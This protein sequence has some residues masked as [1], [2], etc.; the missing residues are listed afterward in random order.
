MVGKRKPALGNGLE[1]MFGIEESVVEE[2]K[3]NVSRETF[4]RL[5]EIEPNRTQPRRN[6][7]E[8]ALQE[9]ADS[10]KQYGVIQ[11]IVVQK[12]GKRYE[13]IAG[14]RRWRAARKA[15]LLEVPVIVKEFAP[16]DI[17][18]IA[19]IENIQ[20][21][22]LNPIE[23]AQ[24]YSRL[25]QEHHLKQDELAE[26][27]AKNRVTITNSMRLLKLDERVQQMLIDNMLTGG[28]A[29]A[30]LAITDKDAQHT[31]ALRVFDE[32]LSVR[33]T[34]SLVKR[35]LTQDEKKDDKP[36]KTQ[37]DSV[38]YRDI[39]NRMKDILGTKVEIKK[40]AKNKGR[41][42][43]EYYSM[44]ELERLIELINRLK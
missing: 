7:D 16:E 34:E 28:H 41:I 31:L 36:V 3:E 9:L 40:K 1:G 2:K 29:R 20:R 10:I 19:L 17:F 39:E 11:P 42:E 5:S 21:E 8:D 44:E 14:E 43:I 24:A 22:D 18:A 27:V 12:K 23:E 13:I 6:F 30:L 38:I 32:K 33:E 4:L 26:K 25:I 15:G 37:D 35:I